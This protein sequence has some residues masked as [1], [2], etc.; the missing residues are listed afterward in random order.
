MSRSCRAARD[1]T[2]LRCGTRSWK[3]APDREWTLDK[4]R[5]SALVSIHASRAPVSTRSPSRSRI[6]V[7]R[8]VISG[9]T[10][11]R[12]ASTRPLPD[13]K[14]GGPSGWSACQMHSPRLRRRRPEP[15]SQS[16]VCDSSSLVPMPTCP[17]YTNGT[18]G[19]LL[20]GL[21]I[22]MAA[23]RKFAGAAKPIRR[24]AELFDL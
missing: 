9:P 19:N 16:A 20:A 10:S 8:P 5:S 24:R 3:L 14:A 15:Q 21:W 6:S 17:D 1:E 11:T 2:D 23:G 4:L 13:A 7:T 18:T 22:D 12:S